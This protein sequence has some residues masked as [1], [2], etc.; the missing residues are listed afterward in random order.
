M[1]RSG[2]KFFTGRLKLPFGQIQLIGSMRPNN[3]V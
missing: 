2:E 1:P 3:D